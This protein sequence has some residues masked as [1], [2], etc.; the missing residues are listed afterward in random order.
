MDARQPP[1]V[2][3]QQRVPAE[4]GHLPGP[5]RRTGLRRLTRPGYP[6]NDFL[7]SP[8]PAGDRVV[9]VSDRR[10]PDVCCNDLFV[11]RSDGSGL[12]R[13]P[14]GDLNGVGNPDWGPAP[15]D[16]GAGAAAGATGSQLRSQAGA[17][18]A[19]ARGCAPGPEPQLTGPCG[20]RAGLQERA[21]R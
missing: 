11:M 16:S 12:H 13:V 10:Y 3:Q 2:D 6:N 18:T 4:R 9:F 14:T 21:G 17:A 7:P 19:A 20:A 8:S 1:A 15:R 5:A